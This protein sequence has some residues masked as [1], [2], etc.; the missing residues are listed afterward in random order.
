MESPYFMDY[1]WTID[2]NINGILVEYERHPLDVMG[3][4]YPPV[5]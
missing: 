5:I 4:H 2:V 1:E 3:S